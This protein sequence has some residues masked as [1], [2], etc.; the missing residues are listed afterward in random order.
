MKT[1]RTIF[2]FPLDLLAAGVFWLL[3]SLVTLLSTVCLLMLMLVTGPFTLLVWKDFTNKKCE[4]IL[5]N[6]EKDIIQSYNMDSICICNISLPRHKNVNFRYLEFNQNGEQ[7][8]LLLHGEGMSS[9]GML[10]II[11][12]L[13]KKYHIIALDIPGFGRSNIPSK[14]LMYEDPI[15][16]IIFY[17]DEFCV[18]RGLNKFY[19]T[20]H[21]FGAYLALAY[22]DKYKNKIEKLIMIDPIGIFPGIGTL[23]AFWAVFYK[24]K[25]IY[26]PYILG[27]WGRIMAYYT[28]DDV[29]KWFLLS[30]PDLCCQNIIASLININFLGG[31]W[32]NTK[33]D[34]LSVLSIHTSLIYGRYDM[35]VGVHQ[36]KALH[37]MFKYDLYIVD[38]CGHV[39]F[40][41]PN[42][43]I[44]VAKSIDDFI[45]TPDER[46]FSITS[47]KL[48]PESY[49]TG[50]NPMSVPF[51]V[52][53]MYTDTL[54]HKP[55][56]F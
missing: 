21:S 44:E 2:C 11:Q 52:R 8:L 40:E 30:Q 53:D 42:G 32:N 12:I 38:K 50:F 15:W 29:H 49:K 5:Y 17:I 48:R 10:P 18:L 28:L 6:I 20:G 23:G 43:A 31:Y 45:Q 13:A 37:D 24:F 7:T 14:S 35:I 26:F 16:G 34:V 41:T 55:N 36:G 22:A 19:I 1:V 33:L 51:V 3:L 27:R 39:P 9:I 25:L 46:S 4:K 54:N 56:N 47:V